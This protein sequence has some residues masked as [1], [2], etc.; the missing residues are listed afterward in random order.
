MQALPADF[1]VPASGR[2]QPRE[3]GKEGALAAARGPDD[4]LVLA[5]LNLP[6]RQVKNRGAALAVA[7]AGNADQ[8]G[9][10]SKRVVCFASIG[11]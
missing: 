7:K 10:G 4:K 6:V 5:G 3:D 8:S 1:D 2:E 9:H 11:T